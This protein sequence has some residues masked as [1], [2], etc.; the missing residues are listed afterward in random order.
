MTWFRA[1]SV[2]VVSAIL[3]VFSG[4]TQ[5]QDGGTPPSNSAP[6]APPEGSSNRGA[7]GVASVSVPPLISGR[8]QLE[9]GTAPPEPAR[10]ERACFGTVRPEG[11]T[12]AKG[13]FTIQLGQTAGVLPDASVDGSEGFRGRVAEDGFESTGRVNLT[14][15]LSSCEIRA[16][17]VGYISGSVPLS[18][19]GDIGGSSIGTIVLRRHGNVEGT[20]V[21]ATGLGAPAG[22]R[23]AF[24]KGVKAT[25]KDKWAEARK[26]FEKAIALHPGWA[27]AWFEMGLAR[28]HLQELER[29]RSCYQRALESDR[30]FVKPYLQLAALEAQA[31]SWEK[32]TAIAAAVFKLDPYNFPSI[33]YLDAVAQYN[34]RRLD[35]AEKSAREAVKLDAANS[36]PGAHHILGAILAAKGDLEGAAVALRTFLKIAP[37][38]ADAPQAQKRLAEVERLAAARQNVAR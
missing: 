17:L 12:N 37:R 9:D 33:Y 16:S 6:T 2:C 1:S 29:A 21:S 3:L 10:L 7:V 32:V 25:R 23:K 31:K 13:R 38:A 19:H 4:A 28:E 34:L 8:V 35:A 30:R 36:F 18:R 26:Q 20:T 14:A 15:D 27:D 11:Y 22:A 5:A 24:D